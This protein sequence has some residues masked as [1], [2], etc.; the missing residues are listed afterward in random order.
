EMLVLHVA[1]PALAD[2]AIEELRAERSKGP[3]YVSPDEKKGPRPPAESVPVDASPAPAAPMGTGYARKELPSISLDAP[4]E[5]VD[6]LMQGDSGA[7]H[8]IQ[9]DEPIKFGESIKLDDKIK[10]DDEPPAPK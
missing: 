7:E 8:K 4:P 5:L 3:R 1:N 10:L 2:A 6:P 9:F